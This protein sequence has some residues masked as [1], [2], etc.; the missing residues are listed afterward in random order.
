MKLAKE[1]KRAFFVLLILSKGDFLR[2]VFYLNVECIEYTFRIYTLLHIKK[3]S[4]TFPCFCCLFL[5]S[6]KAF[7][8]QFDP[9]C[10]F[11][12]N[13]SSRERVK[14]WLFL[15]FNIIISHIFPENFIEIILAVQRIWRFSPSILN[16]FINFSGFLTFPC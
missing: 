6:L 9:S 10:G 1:K 4:Y 8:P 11:S 2:I 3:H 15:T 12:K 5:K 16:I 13:V 7:S 14:P